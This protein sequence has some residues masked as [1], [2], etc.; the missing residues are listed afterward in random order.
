[1]SAKV[2]SGITVTSVMKAK[3]LTRI[4]QNGFRSVHYGQGD[5]VPSAFAEPGGYLA[6][7]EL[8]ASRRRIPWAD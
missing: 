3:S 4:S 5:D 2:E 7:V 6:Q 1:M 8:R